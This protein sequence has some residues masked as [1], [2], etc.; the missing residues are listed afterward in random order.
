MY[1]KYLKFSA[2][3]AIVTVTATGSALAGGFSRGEANTDILF[4]D[5]TVI[6]Q[7]SLVFVS[8]QRKFDTINGKAGTDGR[9]TEDFWIPELALKA[10]ISDNFGCALTYTQPFGGAVSYG[11]QAQAQQAA[12]TGASSTYSKSFY[13]NEYGATCD[14]KFDAGPGQFHV[15]G[16]GF[17]QDFHYTAYSSLGTL[18]LD[19][20]QALGYRIG[21][22][23]DIPQYA[24]RAELM[25]RSEVKHDPNGSFAP[26]ALGANPAVLGKYGITKV[27][28]AYGSGTLPQSLKLS[29]QSGIAPDWLVYGSVE[30]TDWSVLQTL[31]YH[32]GPLPQNDPYYWKD[33]WTVQGGVGHK[34][35]ETVSG[36]L[37]LTWDKGVGTGADIQTDTWT[38]GAGAEIKAG[39]GAFQLGGAI[40]YLTSGSQTAALSKS[41][42]ATSDGS[43]AYAVAASYKIKF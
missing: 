41:Y 28:S 1:L 16:G 10:R 32:I 17:L 11:K 23:Y 35:N 22:A 21:V 14:L 29:L 18:K 13:S 8:P 34:F 24:M 15:L 26:T 4:D 2:L 20:D 6:G 9:Y 31:D 12:L 40:S 33:G 38:V 30:W 39:P 25:Y 43:W 19:D 7:G 5:G 37:N 42:N 3:A 27:V 36:T